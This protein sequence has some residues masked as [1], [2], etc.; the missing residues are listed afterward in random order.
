MTDDVCWMMKEVQ[1][2]QVSRGDRAG[3][4]RNS[5]Y[6]RVK[7]QTRIFFLFFGTSLWFIALFQ[8]CSLSIWRVEWWMVNG[9]CWGVFLCLLKPWDWMRRGTS[10]RKKTIGLWITYIWWKTLN[11]YRSN[12]RFFP[13]IVLLFIV[14]LPFSK[15]K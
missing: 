7:L 8:L 4:K 9:E 13:F 5:S 3:W 12:K 6:L 10:K 11:M 1:W 15:I 2:E 14:Q